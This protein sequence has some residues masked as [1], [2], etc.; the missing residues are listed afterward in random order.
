VVGRIL[1]SAHCH[2]IPEI[3]R[4][5]LDSPLKFFSTD[6]NKYFQSYNLINGL[7]GVDHGIE[8]VADIIIDNFTK[9]IKEIET[10]YGNA[11]AIREKYV[12]ILEPDLSKLD[13]QRAQFDRLAYTFYIAARGPITGIPVA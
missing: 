9:S 13:S 7:A 3:Y 12:K 5:Y 1:L 10:D 11:E 6:R 8:K 4:K 2:D